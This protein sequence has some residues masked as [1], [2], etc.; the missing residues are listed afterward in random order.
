[1]ARTLVV[2]ADG[3]IGAALAQRG[4]DVV[5]LT[6]RDLD[7][8]APPASWPELP[9]VDVAFLCAAES[10]LEAC[11]RDP[12]GTRRV[13]VTATVEL[14]RRLRDR[15]A[16]IVFLS[17]NHVFD[18]REPHRRHDEAVCPVNAYGRQKAEAETRLNEGATLRLTK[19]LSDDAPLFARW[20]RALGRGEP[21]VAFDDMAVAPVELAVVVEALE[22]I[23]RARV[24]GVYQ[25][26]GARDVTY[27]DLAVALAASLSAAPELVRR[28]S[29]R[30]RGLPAS[31]LPRHTTLAPR[32][33]PDGLR[34]ASGIIPT[35]DPST[36]D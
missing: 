21:I 34:P 24:P 27:H 13:N 7:L 11:E 14:A 32:L 8:S 3:L 35:L 5:G 4:D 31:F 15:G 1:M 18:G 16:F 29:A 6:R 30:A 28:E 33:P 23:A 9:A 26:S 17:S 20:R 2:G 10:R 22:A 36:I 19:V 12:E 25:L